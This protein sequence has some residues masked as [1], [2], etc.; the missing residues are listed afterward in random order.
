MAT[1][2][3]AAIEAEIQALAEHYE[4]GGIRAL[5][6]LIVE[7]V[8]RQ[9]PTGT[10]IFLLTNPAY[11]PLVGNISGWPKGN[12]NGGWIDFTLE[13]AGTAGDELH[14]A[15]AR[16]FLLRGG[17]HLLV[18]RDTETLRVAKTRIIQSLSWGLVLTLVLGIAGGVV[19]SGRMLRRLDAIN[20]TSQHIM[21]GDLSQRVL[22]SGDNDEFDQLARNLN[23]MLD[24]IE[25]LLDDIHRV[26]DNIAH[27]MKTPLARLR[28]RLESLVQSSQEDLATRH[29]L[30][31]ALRES[32]QLLTMFNVVLRIARI[33]ATPHIQ[34]T[35]HVNLA[36]LARDL[37]DLYEPL[38]AEK[39]LTL[40]CPTNQAVMIAGD[41]DMLFQ[42]FSNLIDNA[43]KYAPSESHVVLDTD[44]GPKPFFEIRDQ[45]PGIPETEH[46]R[47]FQRFH[48]LDQ[49]H[50]TP[51]N[52]LGLS[53]V[54]AVT[55]VHSA[56][57]SLSDNRPGLAVRVTFPAAW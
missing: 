54:R 29:D 11:Q 15:R 13:D 7:R 17:F 6:Q 52:G 16:P 51:G 14:M 39:N 35:E 46:E 31:V 34:P 22:L 24:K 12:E 21:D 5:R 28:A 49:S 2:T 19:I 27:D 18:G 45:G 32:D 44:P 53:L 4:K 9:H 20:D 37:I 41:R 38:A 30:D 33:E 42:A 1:Q 25:T 56:T 3:D 57:I 36:I 50:S 10:T 40:S 23:R 26:S 8:Q 43:I 48:R 55:N 47:V